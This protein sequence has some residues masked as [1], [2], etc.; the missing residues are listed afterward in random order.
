MNKRKHALANGG[1]QTIWGKTNRYMPLFLYLS[2]SFIMMIVAACNGGK[3]YSVLEKAKHLMAERPDSALSLLRN[4]VEYND[5]N[6]RQAADFGRLMASCKLRLGMSIAKDAL[7][8]RSLDYYT[9]QKDTALMVETMQLMA[10]KAQWRERQDEAANCYVKALTLVPATNKNIRAQLYMSASLAYI[11]PE[12]PKDYAK[13][14]A[15]AYKALAEN[16][17]PSYK[18]NAY[19]ILSVCYERIGRKQAAVDYQLK[20]IFEVYD[21]RN[22]NE[23]YNTYVT[24]YAN[25]EGVDVALCKRLLYGLPRKYDGSRYASLGFL[26]LNS[27]RLDSARICLDRAKAYYATRQNVFTVNTRNVLG[28]LEACLRMAEGKPVMMSNVVQNDSIR[29]LAE[30]QHRMAEEEADVRASVQQRL[31]DERQQ[32]QLL[33]FAVVTIIL[34]G[35]IV[36]FM[37]DRRMKQR[38]ISMKRQLDQSRVRQIEQETEHDD[39]GRPDLSVMW[40]ERVDCS[41]EAFRGSEWM[42]RLQMMEGRQG[43]DHP[44]MTVNDRKRLREA[45]LENFTDVVFDI[46]SEGSSLNMDDIL[47]CLLTLLHLSN[48]TISSC[49]AA[50]DGALRTRK[51]RLKGKL[52]AEMSAFVFG[53][54]TA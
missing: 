36:F 45:L 8:N 31:V 18:A 17:S 52:S 51:S 30:R 38:Y 44:F 29:L 53:S 16:P 15:Y 26:Y 49:L 24:N 50:T 25:I 33:S 32:R 4:D 1:R 13:A 35:L 23:D 21:I 9:G 47:L 7:L 39:A 43:T 10:A 2:L 42:H 41:V 6:D 20:S 40:K 54:V 37:R 5:L 19:Q 22:K 12:M 46:K 48:A 11:Q 28:T 3:D 34:V 27:H 14:I